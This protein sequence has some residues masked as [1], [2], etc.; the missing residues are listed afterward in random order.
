MRMRPMTEEV[1]ADMT[2]AGWSEPDCLFFVFDAH[3]QVCP[4]ALDLSIVCGRDVLSRRLGDAKVPQGG[5]S[6][7][8]CGR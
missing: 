4:I 5:R 8:V 1:T 2:V 7:C 6:G 3:A